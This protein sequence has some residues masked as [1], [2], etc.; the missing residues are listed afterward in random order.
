MLPVTRFNHGQSIVPYNG[1]VAV[2]ANSRV[3][4]KDEKRDSTYG[5]TMRH[6]KEWPVS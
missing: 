6:A 1:T 4:A 3:V 2:T 5:E